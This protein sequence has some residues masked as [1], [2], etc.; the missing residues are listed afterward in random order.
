MSAV[1]AGAFL[2]FGLVVLIAAYVLAFAFEP[3]NWW[4]LFSSERQ[5]RYMSWWLVTHLL[6]VTAASVPFAVTI[7]KIAGP[8]WLV[9][10]LAVAALALALPTTFSIATNFSLMSPTLQAFSALEALE[11]WV[12][13][14]LGTWVVHWLLTSS[15][16]LQSNASG[17]A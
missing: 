8:R 14:P 6:V 7:A 12:V 2:Y 5:A 16:S 4:P 1:L 3:P 15:K 13:L 17:I 9:A 11:H 10:A